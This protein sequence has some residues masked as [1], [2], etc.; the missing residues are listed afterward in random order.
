MPKT[1]R[2]LEAEAKPI[3]REP[4]SPNNINLSKAQFVELQKKKAARKQAMKEAAEK[5]DKEQDAKEENKEESTSFTVKHGIKIV[6]RF[7]TRDEAEGFIADSD[8]AEKLKIYEKKN[9]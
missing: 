7:K 1:V 6:G 5:F 4:H 8:K 3:E 2:Q 9:K